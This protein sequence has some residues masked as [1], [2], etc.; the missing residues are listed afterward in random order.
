MEKI[1][2][3]LCSI[4]IAGVIIFVNLIFTNLACAQHEGVVLGRPDIVQQEITPF[5]PLSKSLVVDPTRGNINLL[6]PQTAIPKESQLAE[7]EIKTERRV[8]RQTNINTE[9]GTQ[10][11]TTR[12][13]NE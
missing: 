11:G 10:T 5:I 6:F 4:L 12:N 2:N 9:T 13:R 8:I 7:S 1:C 3:Y